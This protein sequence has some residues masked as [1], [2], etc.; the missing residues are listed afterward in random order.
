MKP[1]LGTSLVVVAFF[2]M[3]IGFYWLFTEGNIPIGVA[4]VGAGT[5]AM[6]IGFI[7]NRNKK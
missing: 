4:W 7:I 3:L 5:V 2:W 1:G 6:V